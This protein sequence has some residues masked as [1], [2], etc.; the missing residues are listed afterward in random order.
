MR[1]VENH[2]KIAKISMVVLGCLSIIASICVVVTIYFT[3]ADYRLIKNNYD[4][5]KNE[6]NI[7]SFTEDDTTY[8]INNSDIFEKTSDGYLINL[9]KLKEDNTNFLANDYYIDVSFEIN[10]DEQAFSNSVL[11]LYKNEQLI[12]QK[13]AYIPNTN[14]YIKKLKFDDTDKNYE[15]KIEYTDSSLTD[16]N[17]KIEN[18][19]V[20]FYSLYL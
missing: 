6:N 16:L 20:Q 5:Y 1:S 14:N 19:K 13:I 18:I 15:L 9:D 12:S 2:K 11:N 7:V 17:I 10:C 8:T 4:I 3:T